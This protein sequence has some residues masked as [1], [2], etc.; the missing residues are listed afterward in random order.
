M[1]F[2][3]FYVLISPSNCSLF[4]S[5]L[6]ISNLGRGH[7]L[8]PPVCASRPSPR[9]ALPP[10][11]AMQGEAKPEQLG[12]CVL[13][14]PGSWRGPVWV[15]LYS[16]APALPFV[17]VRCRTAPG[18]SHPFLLPWNW[19]WVDAV[20]LL[21]P[22]GVGELHPSVLYG[23]QEVPHCPIPAAGPE[24]VEVVGALFWLAQCHAG[25]SYQNI[26]FV[27]AEI[28]FE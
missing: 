15:A 10:P 6:F 1:I 2:C 18:P 7:C 25:D 4:L 11:A 28:L 5:F 23:L 9:L 26:H 16:A 17:A 20:V 27:V 24:K 8:Q 13:P 14:W 12:C 21:C 3:S 19:Q 22:S